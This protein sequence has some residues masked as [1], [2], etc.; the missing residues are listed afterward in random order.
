M[1]ITVRDVDERIFR[2]FKAEAVKEGMQ[3]GKALTRAMRF[4]LDRKK[5]KRPKKSILDL[6]PF[7]WG[8]GSERSSIEVDQVLYGD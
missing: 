2:E 7:D 1:N 4:W 8:E 5:E 6:K 3:L